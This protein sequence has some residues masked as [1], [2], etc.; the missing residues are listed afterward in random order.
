V[1]GTH[2]TLPAGH[3]AVYSGTPFLT[4]K[5]PRSAGEQGS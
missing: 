1:K 3:L 5:G 4:G 2:D